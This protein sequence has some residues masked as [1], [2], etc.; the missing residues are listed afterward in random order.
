MEIK[1]TNF[2]LH[3]MARIHLISSPRNLSTALMY[4]FAQRKDMQVV[5]EPLYAHYLQATGK[6]HPG[7]TQILESQ[8]SDGR[9]VLEAMAHGAYGKPHVFFKGMAH[10]LVHI[11]WKLLLPFT[12]VIYLRN[13]QQ[14]IASF[15][16]VIEQPSMED[17]GVKLQYELFSFLKE[18]G[19]T[20]IVLDSGS[21]LANPENI[22]RKLCLALRIPFDRAMLSW[23][24]GPRPED[25]VW[26]PY[27]YAN[28]HRSTGFAKQVT[29]SRPLPSSL[30]PLY[31]ECLPFYE[32]MVKGGLEFSE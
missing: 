18:N 14:L 24:A 22:L 30:E 23:E 32:E 11:D 1:G 17:I 4:A 26:A 9:K 25:G 2:N 19:N 31:K 3:G 6:H 5:D 29:S 28:V 27:W 10:H 21:L 8:V 16:K 13:P 7:R 15:A 20:P 12:H